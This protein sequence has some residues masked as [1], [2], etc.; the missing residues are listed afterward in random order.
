LSI[1]G[2]APHCQGIFGTYRAWGCSK[3]PW[4]IWSWNP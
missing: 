2:I 3:M 4:H 1:Q